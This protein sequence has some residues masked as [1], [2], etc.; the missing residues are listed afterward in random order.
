MYEHDNSR[1]I[2]DF[3]FEHKLN[4]INAIMFRLWGTILEHGRLKE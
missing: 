3:A 4:T 2:V 1:L